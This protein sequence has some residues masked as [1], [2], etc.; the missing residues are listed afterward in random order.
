MFF[1]LPWIPGNERK[2]NVSIG[3]EQQACDDQACGARG[4]YEEETGAAF[5][6]CQFDGLESHEEPNNMAAGASSLPICIAAEE[7]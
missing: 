3:L 7:Q 5:T 1:L 6:L 4:R 2:K